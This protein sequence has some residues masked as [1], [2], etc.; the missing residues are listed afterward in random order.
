MTAPAT[1]PAV[2]TDG[3]PLMEAIALAVWEHCTR[4]G[5]NTVVDDPRNIAAV[6]AS[7]ARQHAITDHQAKSQ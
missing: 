3:D 1:K 5:Y 2:W 6:A 7:V 4:D